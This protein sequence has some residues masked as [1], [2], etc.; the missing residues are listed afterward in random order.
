MLYQLHFGMKIAKFKD[1]CLH[2]FKKSTLFIKYE[3]EF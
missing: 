1:S 2:I 3:V